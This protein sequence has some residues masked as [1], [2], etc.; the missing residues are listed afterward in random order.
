MHVSVYTIKRIVHRKGLEE[1]N[2]SVNRYITRRSCKQ[3]QI[4]RRTAQSCIVEQMIKS[5]TKR[6]RGILNVTFMR[7]QKWETIVFTR[8][9]H[10]CALKGI[11]LYIRLILYTNLIVIKKIVGSNRKIDP[12]LFYQSWGWSDLNIWMLR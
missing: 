12:V 9:L 8:T 3:G 2:G 5:N 1:V 11:I 6:S 10:P 4:V 7:N